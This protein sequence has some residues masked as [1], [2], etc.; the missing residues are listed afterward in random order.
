MGTLGR[1][2]AAGVDG[3]MDCVVPALVAVPVARG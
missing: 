3:R 1:P 2:G